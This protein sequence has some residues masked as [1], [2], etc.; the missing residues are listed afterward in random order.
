MDYYQAVVSEYLAA[1]R[2]LFINTECCIQ[3][4][5]G[6]N[7]DTSGPHW[8]ADAV[9]CDFR[10][11]TIFLCEISYSQSLAPL[12][13]RLSAWAQS[14]DLLHLALVR[15][16]R[17]PAHWPVRPWLFVPEKLIPLLLKRLK[18]VSAVE[19]PPFVPRITPL[20]M[21]QPWLYK[22]WNRVGE[23]DKPTSIPLAM[24]Y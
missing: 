15:D 10:D 21:V 19:E 12:V 24:Q 1:D 2:A 9:V 22:S 18:I 8:Y 3:L 4:N 7:P 13:K 11:S 17:L 14:W 20:E 16:C 23:G 5:E 6:G